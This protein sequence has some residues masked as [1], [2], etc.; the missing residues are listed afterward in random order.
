MEWERVPDGQAA[1]A[2]ELKRAAGEAC[3]FP[4]AFARAFTLGE[5]FSLLCNGQEA[6]LLG[7]TEAALRTWRR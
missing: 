6:W 4:R 2:R 1:G 7:R 3:K 5:P